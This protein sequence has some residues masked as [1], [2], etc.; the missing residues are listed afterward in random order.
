MATM[1]E[2]ERI[3]TPSGYARLMAELDYLRT[4]RRQEVS[5]R[6]KSA[7]E[8]GVWDSPEYQAA[9]EEQSFVE[10]RIAT[11]ERLLAKAEVVEIT[12]T[13]AWP[14]VEIGSTVVLRDE[15]GE[16]EQ[17][18]IVGAMESQPSEGRISNQS[19]VGR[20]VLGH[21]PGETVEVETPM[22]TRRLTIVEIH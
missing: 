22:G 1:G 9:R 15:E 6:L 11:L 4:V 3:L 20:A 5:E 21:R 2:A 14:T 10:G 18:D 13:T 17:Y 8:V 12:P 7:R 19:P 16:I